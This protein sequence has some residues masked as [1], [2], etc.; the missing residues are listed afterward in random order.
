MRHWGIVVSLFY[1]VVLV[2]L[3]LPSFIL[4][5]V[6]GDILTVFVDVYKG[7]IVPDSIFPSEGATGMWV[8]Y[9]W[10]FFLSGGQ[11]LLLFLTIDT[12]W[13]L[14]RRRSHLALTVALSAF[15]FAVLCL[16]VY[17]SVLDTMDSKSRRIFDPEGPIVLFAWCLSLW[18]AWAIVFYIY[19]K[20]TSLYVDKAVSWLLKGSI[21]ELLIAVSAHVVARQRNECTHPIG[22]SLGIVTGLAIMLMCFGPGVLAL[23]RKR[24][25][26]Y[27][28][29]D[30]ASPTAEADSCNNITGVQ[31][32]EPTRRRYAI[33]LLVICFFITGG[34][35]WWQY[36]D[37]TYED[38]M[39][40]T[41]STDS[42][43]LETAPG[44]ATVQ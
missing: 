43:S 33:R 2:G 40:K 42:K 38:I 32:G 27:Q 20:N 21:L 26:G 36:L 12:T 1:L 9:T 14:R 13:R 39:S 3:L 17:F 34:L 29:P 18:M 25:A 16:A 8:A 5:I 6:E 23:L 4:L 28:K 35:A 31:A 22:T 37:S 7:L 15:L 24:M 11:V 19:C 41:R 44:A 10:I 30:Q